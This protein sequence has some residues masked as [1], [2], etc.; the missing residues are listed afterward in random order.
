MKLGAR[1]FLG[2]LL[3]MLVCFWFPLDWVRDNLRIRYLEGVEDPLVDQANILAAKVGLEMENGI[4]DADAWSRAFADAHNRPVDAGIY[5]FLKPR[6][7]M[8][9]Y[10][11][12][13]RGRTLFNSLNPGHSGEDFSA[14]RDVR[15]TLEG[16]YGARSTQSDPEDPTS[17]VLYVAAPI[18]I[19]NNMAGVLTVAKP[20]TNINNFLKSAKPRI[21]QVGVLSAIVAMVLSLLATLWFTRPIKR[22]TGYAEDV[23]NGNRVP[24]PRLDSSEIGEMGQAFERMQEA[25]EGKKYVEQYVQNLTH[26]LKSPLSAIRGAAELMEEEDMPYDQRRRFLANINTE[27]GRLQKV[28]DRMLALSALEARKI[29]QKQERVK[30]LSLVKTILESC[31]PGLTRKHLSTS[32]KIPDDLFVRGDSF[33][34]HQAFLN[35]IQNAIDFSPPDSCISLQAEKKENRVEFSVTD[36]GDGIPDYALPKVFEK[37]YSLHRPDNGKKS[38]GLGLNFVKE[39]TALHGGTIDISNQ[40]P[41]GVRAMIYLPLKS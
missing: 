5:A 19:A 20:T 31:Q 14:W 27:A 17:S 11:T 38:T 24:F 3:I 40:K 8:H 26:E 25:L 28:V 30:L 37:F 29:L 15:L 13:T 22:L 39:I 10:I 36:Q 41:N 21:V 12:D 34:L 18:R 2:N 35:L 4:F 7:D 9:V 33:L 32:V 1:I 16:E 6:V 23:S